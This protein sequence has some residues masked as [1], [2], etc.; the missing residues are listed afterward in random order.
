[1]L[2]ATPQRRST[3]ERP[4]ALPLTENEIQRAVFKHIRERGRDGVFA[5]HPKNGGV[6]QRGRR[7][8]INSGL[9]VVSGVPDVIV[10]HRGHAHCLELKA[11]KGKLSDEQ[12]HVA[13]R[14]TAAGMSW[15]VTYG[16]DEALRWLEERDLLKGR[17]T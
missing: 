11:E 12:E 7:S 13:T 2:E 15:G 6:H 17:A 8:G 10:F 14:I 1:M 3:Q 5:F 9:G 16:L 4:F